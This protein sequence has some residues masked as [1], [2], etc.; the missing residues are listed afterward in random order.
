MAL[1]Y[2]EVAEILKIID[3]SDCEELVLD[4]ETIWLRS[5]TTDFMP[6]ATKTALKI[7]ISNQNSQGNP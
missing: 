3:A 5:W 1:T 4:I 7:P 6:D 2:R